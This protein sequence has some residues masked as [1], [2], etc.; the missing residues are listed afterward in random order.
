M[1]NILKNISLLI[2]I[3][4]SIILNAQTKSIDQILSLYRSGNYDQ[5][6][7]EINYAVYNSDL[8]KLSTTWYY[9]G[10]IY[11]AM[12]NRNNNKVYGLDSAY[13]SLVMSLRLDPQKEFLN[14]II[15]EFN[16]LA[17]NYYRR[18]AIEFNNEK[19]MLAYK[20]FEKALDINKTPLIA[21][22]D[23][24][25]IFYSAIAAQNSNN[26]I[27][28]KK[29]YEKLIFLNCYNIDIYTS[30]GDIYKNENNIKKA[31]EIYVKGLDK[32]I[33]DMKLIERLI[34]INLLYGNTDEAFK[35]IKIGQQKNPEDAELYFYQA[36]LYNILNQVENAKEAYIEGLKYDEN[37]YSANYSLGVIFYNQAIKFR[38]SADQYKTSNIP[39]Y[40]SE[41]SQFNINIM[42][43]K[44]LL[45]NAYMQ[46]ITDRNLNLCLI[47]VYKLL[48]RDA[49]ADRIKAMMKE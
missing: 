42:K 49:A 27:D 48:N 23:T 37:N 21:R 33:G 30:L 20:S 31:N 28:A 47:E 18:G 16:L 38:K 39:K 25:L 10:Q 24:M 34:S 4:I 12:Y 41:L 6:A 1:H 40:K 29:L 8:G 46:N 22:S 3:H 2:F 9:R 19:Y 44:D 45:E 15:A 11:Q 36:Q 32:N 17:S 14:N 26:L 43:S 35:Y 7:K 5:A 13:F